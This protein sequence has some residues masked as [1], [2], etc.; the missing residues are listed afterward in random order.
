MKIRIISLFVAVCLILCALASCTSGNT[1]ADTTDKPADT[2]NKPTETTKK[3][4]D[5]TTKDPDIDENGLPLKR[6][7]YNNDPGDISALALFEMNFTGKIDIKKRTGFGYA[8][9]AQMSE[10]GILTQRDD[11]PITWDAKSSNQQWTWDGTFHYMPYTYYKDGITINE[12][13]MGDVTGWSWKYD[14]DYKPI[15]PVYF[16]NFDHLQIWYT[17][18]PNG[19]WTR[20]DCTVTG[21]KNWPSDEPTLRGTPTQA[22]QFIGPNVTA[23]FFIMYD[24]DPQKCELWTGVGTNSFYG[25][26][27]PANGQQ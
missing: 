18:D 11:R 12:I 23:K 27:D 1:P 2:T 25:I 22:I 7:L 14:A 8:I 3:P 17:D 20:W 13:I 24:P 6:T 16:E 9:D 10:D 21:D 19:T 4:E 26:Y 15:D 5:V